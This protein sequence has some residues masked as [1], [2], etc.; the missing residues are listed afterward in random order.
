MFMKLFEGTHS[1]DELPEDIHL[2]LR[3]LTFANLF[4][5]RYKNSVYLPSPDTLQAQ[6]KRNAERAELWYQ[7][8]SH[9]DYYDAYDD[10]NLQMPSPQAAHETN[11]SGSILSEKELSDNRRDLF[12]HLRIPHLNEDSIP[13]LESSITFLDILPQ[14]ME[15]C[16]NTIPLDLKREWMDGATI[17]MLHAALEQIL[18]YG[19][20]MVQAV[21][22]AFA[23]D[24]VVE[25]THSSSDSINTNTAAQIDSWTASKSSL[26][27]SFFD[28]KR[29]VQ[30]QAHSLLDRF[31][32]FDFEGRVLELLGTLVEY[33]LG[34]FPP[35]LMQLEAG[36]LSGFSSEETRAF[37]ERLTTGGL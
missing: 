31:P 20:D 24:W 27:K 3:V 10:E 32:L 25:N 8:R 9:S 5:R 1:G 29:P 35:L 12:V 37:M 33:L 4:C 16:D 17:F 14:Y 22:E 11:G 26:K 7:S 34:E 36:K 15:L 2:K 19:N 28:K 13:S 6:R 21:N 30:A 18:V 23:W